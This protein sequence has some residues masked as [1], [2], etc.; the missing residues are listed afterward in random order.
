MPTL[1]QD[2]EQIAHPLNTV[3]DALNSSLGAV[4]TKLNDLALGFEVWL[5]TS[6]PDRVV[7][8]HEETGR[9]EQVVGKYRTLEATM[10]GYGHVD[11][12]PTDPAGRRIG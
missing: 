2:L 3:S 8:R 1:F 9:N 12:A 6:L 7:S 10:L 4:E 11:A 5:P